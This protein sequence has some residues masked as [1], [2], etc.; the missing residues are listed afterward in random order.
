[1]SIVAGLSRLF[2]NEPNVYA[3]WQQPLCATAF[4]L[5]LWRAN[6]LQLFAI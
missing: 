5:R 2:E 3:I 6:E 4:S 1:M